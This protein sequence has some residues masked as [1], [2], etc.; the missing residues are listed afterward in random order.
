MRLI[1]LL[2][3]VVTASVVC[4]APISSVYQQKCASCHGSKGEKS[5]MAKSIPI[6]GMAVAKIEKNLHDYASGERKAIPVVKM[7][8]KNYLSTSSKDQVHEL[9]EYISAL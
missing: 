1:K 6:K 2:L 4:A 5:A 8:K 9:A 3:P 7:M